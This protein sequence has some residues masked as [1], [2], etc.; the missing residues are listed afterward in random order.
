MSSAAILGILTEGGDIESLGLPDVN[1]SV[2]PNF[3]SGKI[4]PKGVSNGQAADPDCT[5]GREWYFSSG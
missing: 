5:E 2:S 3:L 4:Q 1:R